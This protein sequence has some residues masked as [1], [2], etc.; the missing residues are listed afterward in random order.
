MF[1]GDY[2]KHVAAYP[3]ARAPMP[4]NAISPFLTRECESNERVI[5]VGENLTRSLAL[6]M[7]CK[8]FL[9]IPLTSA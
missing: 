4:M 6:S 8:L 9:L 5:A 2:K 7:D 3:T 1:K